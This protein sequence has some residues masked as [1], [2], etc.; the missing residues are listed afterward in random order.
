MQ[1][2]SNASLKVSTHQHIE[3]T[4]IEVVLGVEG[5]HGVG[6]FIESNEGIDEGGAEGGINVFDVELARA[7]SVHG[8]RPQVTHHLLLMLGLRP[9]CWGNQQELALNNTR[10]FASQ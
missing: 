2:E 1:R 3:L 10:Q 9:S 6:G 5:L 7:G 4:L 8:P